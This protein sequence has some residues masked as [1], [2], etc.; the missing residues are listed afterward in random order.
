[1]RQNTN[2]H[3]CTSLLELTINNNYTEYIYVVYR[4]MKGYWYQRSHITATTN[5]IIT[6]TVLLTCGQ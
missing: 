4:V 6:I 5:L 1:M 2:T 3:T